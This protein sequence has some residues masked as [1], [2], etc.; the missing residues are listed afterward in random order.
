MFERPILLYS[1]YCAYSQQFVNMLLENK[2]IFDIFIR[3][4]IDVNPDTRK[5]PELFYEIQNTLNYKIKEVPTIVIN[6]GEYV[7]SGSEA[8]KWLEYEME[9]LNSNK[10]PPQN[11]FEGFNS[12]EMGS[13][14]DMYSTFGS[15]NLND[16]REQSFK[17]LNK[18]DI[19]IQTPPED[20]TS[21]FKQ[22][23]QHE[24]NNYSKPD[25]T[26]PNFMKGGKSFSNPGKKSEKQ[27]D[28]DVKLQQL[29]NERESM[30][31][32]RP[33]Y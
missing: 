33:R 4:N 9:Q 14:S 16:A 13:F 22:T 1:N 5:R 27:K 2:D 30:T 26:N 19:S 8:F 18:P 11:G 28:F 3:I 23:P 6:N 29:L 15:N 17:F 7:L 32:N 10:S 31:P 20:S 25:F 24:R 12:V 21:S